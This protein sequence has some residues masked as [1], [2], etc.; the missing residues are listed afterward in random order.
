LKNK[1]IIIAGGTGFIGEQIVKYFGKENSL[2]I[3]TR[4]AKHSAN[5]RNNFTQLSDADLSNTKYVKWDA[6]T[7]GDW[8]RELEGSDI[9]I[10]LAGRSVN[11]RYTPK[12]RKEIFNS[13]VNSTRAIGAAIRNCV[14]PPKLWINSSSATIY[15]DEKTKP[16]D[17]YSKEFD[18]DFSVLV[19]KQWEKTFYEQK[20]TNTRRVALR[21]AITF[22]PGGLLK[23]YFNLIKFGLGGRQ[24]SGKQ[25]FTWVHVEDTCRMI[26]WIFDHE[27]I[28][29]SYNC[30]SP[31]PVPNAEFMRALRKATHTRFGL[32]AF[33]WM[34]KIGGFIIGTPTELI[35]K[36]RWVVP[37]KILETGFQFKYPRIEEALADIVN[38]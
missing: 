31:N 10:N 25:M 5:N 15:R 36:S 11:C 16:N 38:R 27:N 37:T 26:E 29:G 18:D 21:M 9:V 6:E 17:E 22:G 23:P 20:I 19:C 33:T 13:R 4:N 2:I 30:C 28:A 14:T 32:P 12:N 7:T 8:A 35:L 34:L 1:K 24:G 3:L